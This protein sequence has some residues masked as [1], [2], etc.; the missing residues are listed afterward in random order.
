VDP[1]DAPE[2]YRP[3]GAR[4]MAVVAGVALSAVMAGLWVALPAD[5]R[6]GFTWLQTA[7]LLLFWA[8][9]IAVLYGIARTRVVSDQFGI[10]VLN[11]YRRHRLA[12]AQVVSISLPRGAP[13]AVIDAADGSV[14]AVMALQGADGDR[15][16]RAVGDLRRRIAQHATREPDR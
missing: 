14:V 3:F 6:A 10:S 9:V 1:A 7:T 13:W 4:V 12:W 15:A 2:T 5:V 8:A 11:G 16:R